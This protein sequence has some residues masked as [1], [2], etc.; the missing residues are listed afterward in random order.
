MKIFEVTRWGNDADGGNGPDTNYL[1]LACDPEEAA[2]LLRD[3]ESELD[4][5]LELGVCPDGIETPAILRGPYLENALGHDRFPLWSRDLSLPGVWFPTP[6]CG[7]GDTTCRYANGQLAAQC[8]WQKGRQHGMS[9][10]WYPGGQPMHRGPYKRGKRVGLHEYWYVNN[11]QA[12]RYE[13]TL[14][15]VRYQ[16]W[17]LNGQLLK[18]A[19]EHWGPQAAPA[20]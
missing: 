1:V 10:R 15:G 13:Y 19:E 14:Q 2:G 7:E 8:G 3:K 18:D 4:A 17:D 11:Q 9:Q 20:D 5:I 12:S 6:P 16:Q